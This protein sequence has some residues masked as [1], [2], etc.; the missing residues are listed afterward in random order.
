MS[1]GWRDHLEEV[2]EGYKPL[3][4]SKMASQAGRAFDKEQAAVKAG[5]QAGANKQMQRRIAMNNPAGRKAQLGK[6]LT[7][8]INTDILDLFNT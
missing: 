4:K 7:T 3:P 1:E 5:D 6:W 8:T 2:S